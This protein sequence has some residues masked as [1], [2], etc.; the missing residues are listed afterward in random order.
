MRVAIFGAS[1]RTGQ[2]L[3]K[4][5]LAREYHITAFVRNPQSFAKRSE[6]L[7]VFQGDV[8]D[9]EAVA[10]AIEGQDGVLC[11]LEAATPLRRDPRLVE[12]VRNIVCAMEQHGVRR[13]VY[14]SFLGVREGRKQLSF[15][16]RYPG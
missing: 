5:A 14:L 8:T 12:G 11:A 2:H 16:G 6:K 13:L 3:V 7:R 15:L 1:G 10:R 4:E 9:V